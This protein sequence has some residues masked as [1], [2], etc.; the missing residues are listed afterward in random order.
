MG[1]TNCKRKK[2]IEVGRHK[3]VSHGPEKQGSMISTNQ[4]LRNFSKL[5]SNRDWIDRY[6][7]RN[8]ATTNKKLKKQKKFMQEKNTTKI[9][10]IP[11]ILQSRSQQIQITGRISGAVVREINVWICIQ[12]KL[13]CPTLS[14]QGHDC[15]PQEDTCCECQDQAAKQNR[16]WSNSNPP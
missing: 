15:L 8:E 16:G 3:T 1:P 2:K 9:K 14:N 7:W 5:E 12:E 6:K 10:S 13:G 11:D 4:K